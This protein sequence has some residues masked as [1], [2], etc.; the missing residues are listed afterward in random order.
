MAD[1]RVK[2]FTGDVGFG[3]SDH[4]EQK[5]LPFRIMAVG[6]FCGANRS[7]A[8]EPAVIDAHDFDK[9]LAKFWPRVLFETPN[10]LGS[11]T[12]LEI[13][14]TPGSLKDFEPQNVAAKIPALA[15]VA[16]FIRRAKGLSDGSI[17]PAE[18]KRDL[19]PIQAVPA[20]RGPLES[21]LSKLGGSAASASTSDEKSGKA[22][23]D[24]IFDLVDTKKKDSGSAIDSF[25]AGLGGGGKGIDVSGA[26]EAAQKLLERQ[27]EHVLANALFANLERNWRGLYLLCK[28]GK[29]ARIEAFDGDFESWNEAV[30][31]AELAGTSE[32]PLAMVLLAE[33]V[34]NS[35]AGLDLLQQWGDA[36]SQIQCAVVF[37]ASEGFL[38]TRV[39]ALAGMDAPANLFD[40][41]RFDKW[42]S[43]R[44][45]DE[46]RWL[47][48]ALNPYLART[49]YSRRKHGIDS[50]SAW[51]SPVWLVGAAVAQ[52]M[53][54]SGWP[55]AHTGAADG[56]ITELPSVIH[57]DGTEHPLKAR[58]ADDALKDLNRAGFTPLISQPNNDSAWVILAPT[59]HKP[60]K[61]EEKGKLGTLAYQLLAARLG[62]MIMRAKANLVV[63]GDMEAS[64]QNFAK[65]LSGL[66]ANTGPGANIDISAQGP[67]L[68]L[69]IRTGRDVLGGV[70]LQLGV[71]TE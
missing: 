34:E 30:F 47:V 64:A 27:L 8:R 10:H 54:R 63:A 19:A 36:G 1:K 46:S 17:K 7:G 49:G 40:D 71:K 3:P 69:N 39:E 29:G 13:D 42:R 59:V 41:S 18:F 65:F 66:L 43:L 70:E 23:V 31:N 14:F 2:G 12:T 22:S 33:A 16:E 35:G 15:P 67:T 53:Q 44:D 45:K 57:E 11:G 58:F 68:V 5:E 56:E 38:G 24:A 26:M 61:A 32:A 28:R 60:S 6:D 48:A 25:A 62:E 9:V 50:A 51:G 52:S 37:E 21:V 55:S 20:L 4:P